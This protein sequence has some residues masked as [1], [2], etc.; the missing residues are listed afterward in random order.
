MTVTNN[1]RSERFLADLDRI[2]ERQDR[3]Q[4]QISS[5]YRVNQPSDGPD[6]I[7]DI[8]Q[9]KSDISRADSIKTNLTRV[10][11]EVDTSEAALRVAE[12]LMERVR[13]LAAQTATT[14][15]TNRIAVSDEVKQIH[16]QLVA[17][18]KTVSEGR[19][20]FGGDSDQSAPYSFN[21]GLAG[22]INPPAVITNTR[23]IEDVNGTKFS[24]AHSA[25]EIFD[26]AGADNVFNAVWM[27][28][29]ALEADDATLVEGA[30]SLI[31]T[32][33]EHIGR[34]LAFYGH[35]QNRVDN[36]K[37]LVQSSLFSR[38]QEL[39]Q[40]RDTDI[41]AALIE[42]STVKVHLQAALGAKA[43]EPRSSLFD[44]LA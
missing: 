23:K 16:E 31:G 19:F 20:V 40:T 8:L 7:I 37:T 26:A 27:L 15:A 4:R 32:S 25:S 38:T 29:K 3:V 13:T 22:G 14:T 30:A 18:T 41:A 42:L 17:I 28:G 6:Q 12:Q 9:L 35:T 5:G 34:E 39:S 2:N 44:F 24:V 33:L 11:A 36:A 43:Q 1:P 21:W 10:S